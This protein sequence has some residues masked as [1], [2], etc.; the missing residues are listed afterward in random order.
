MKMAVPHPTPR[1]VS[2]ADGRALVRSSFPGHLAG[3]ARSIGYA[4]RKPGGLDARGGRAAPHGR[5]SINSLQSRT[6]LNECQL[7]MGRVR[8]GKEL[9]CHLAQISMC[10]L[11]K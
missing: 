5:E 11:N 8:V 6:G 4:P 10:Y 3:N 1:G 2:V 9:K 7:G